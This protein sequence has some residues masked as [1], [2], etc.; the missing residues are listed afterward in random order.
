MGGPYL[1]AYVLLSCLRL[2]AKQRPPVV[3]L[4]HTSKPVQKEGGA[5]VEDDVH[6]DQAIVA[7]PLVVVDVNGLEE[8]VGAGH[9]TVLA[10]RGRFW[11]VK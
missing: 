5:D 6:P 7:E 2:D 11:V 3:F 10:V 4:R 1:L 9:G 8:L